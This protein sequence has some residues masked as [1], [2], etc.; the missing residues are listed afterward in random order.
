MLN[1]ILQARDTASGTAEVLNRLGALGPG[2][3]AGDL[4]SGLDQQPCRSRLKRGETSARCTAA[5]PPADPP[6]VPRVGG[7]VDQLML[8]LTIGASAA[9]IRA[10][11]SALI[12]GPRIPRNRSSCTP[13]VMYCQR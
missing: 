13:L 10:P 11:C 1:G 4:S 6:K 5:I 3:S 8:P 2:L 9:L 12:I 7:R